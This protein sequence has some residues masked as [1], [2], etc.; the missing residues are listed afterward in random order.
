MLWLGVPR[1]SQL[2]A[3]SWC[4]SWLGRG[5]PCLGRTWGLLSEQPSLPPPLPSPSEA[6]PPGGGARA[7]GSSSES[8]SRDTC[9]RPVPCSFPWAPEP[10]VQGASPRP[11]PGGHGAQSRGPAAPVAAV[12]HA[13]TGSKAEGGEGAGCVAPEKLPLGPSLLTSVLRLAAQGGG[14]KAFIRRV[15]IACLAF[16]LFRF[17]DELGFPVA[18]AVLEKVR[19]FCPQAGCQGPSSIPA[20][21]YPP[22]P[23]GPF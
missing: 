5:F 17:F 14:P 23:R 20:P 9:V 18:V 22:S 12:G 11:A 3:P 2:T 15:P 16:P 8:L 19:S 1:D 21:P 6:S 13:W 4:W 7:Q 10:W